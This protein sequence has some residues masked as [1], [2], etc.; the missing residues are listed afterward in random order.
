VAIHPYL[1]GGVEATPATAGVAV[2]RSEQSSERHPVWW[3]AVA[4]SAFVTL[5]TTVPLLIR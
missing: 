3:I 2:D 5:L 4:V 1:P